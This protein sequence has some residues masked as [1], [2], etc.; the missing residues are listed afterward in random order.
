KRLIR[1]L[2]DVT[3]IESGALSLERMLLPVAKTIAEFAAD[4]QALPSSPA[5]ELRLELAENIGDVFADR[6][7]LLQVL[8]NLVTNAEKVA[9]PN[10]MVSLGAS[11]NDGEVTFHVKDTGP[12]ISAEELPHVFERF[13]PKKHTDRR[14]TGLGLP[15]VKGIVE[16]HGGR[17]WAESRV[18]E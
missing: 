7:R 15:I 2:L 6:D 12:G 5:P 11:P 3:R 8:E 14:G 4:R 16:A 13:G 18:G 10:G 1:D 17:V 9:G